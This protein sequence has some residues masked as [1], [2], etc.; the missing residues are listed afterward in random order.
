MPASDPFLHAKID[1]LH[2]TPMQ[3]KLRKLAPMPVGCV[4]LPWP[5][6]T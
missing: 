1:S 6:M 4:F 2:D 5:G 3:R